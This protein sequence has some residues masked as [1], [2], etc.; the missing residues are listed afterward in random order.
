MGRNKPK[1]LEDEEVDEPLED[2]FEDLIIPQNIRAKNDLYDDV[3]MV[4]YHDGV[5]NI[6]SLELKVK[7]RNWKVFRGA[8]M[9][10]FTFFL[11][12]VAILGFVHT[13]YDNKINVAKAKQQQLLEEG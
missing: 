5:L 3:A 7:N 10:L 11:V 12:L 8:L 6:H 13:A 9:T 2:S 1:K 4:E